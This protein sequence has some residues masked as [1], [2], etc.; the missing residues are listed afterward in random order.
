MH[1]LNH[2]VFTVSHLVTHTQAPSAKS[3]TVTRAGKI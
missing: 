1:F 3:V 2:K